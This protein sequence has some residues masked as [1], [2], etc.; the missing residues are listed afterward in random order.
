MGP[1]I[2]PIIF[3]IGVMIIVE[4]SVILYLVAL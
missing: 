1:V 2:V 3:W 4:V